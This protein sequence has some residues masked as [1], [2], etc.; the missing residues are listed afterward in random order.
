MPWCRC[1]R[2]WQR[3]AGAFCELALIRELF[4]VI[5]YGAGVHKHYTHFTR[6]AF[7]WTLCWCVCVEPLTVQTFTIRQIYTDRHII[8]G[9]WTENPGESHRL[10]MHLE[11]RLK[12]LSIFWPSVLELGIY[13]S[14]LI[15]HTT[16]DAHYD[17]IYILTY[18]TDICCV[19][20]VTNI[21]HKSI[22]FICI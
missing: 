15:I 6:E 14:D 7:H 9:L 11:Q 1:R 4:G 10:F 3:P 18:L 8:F 13:A 16:I 17:Y 21:D 12:V 19:S 20:T 22:W 5:R 2:E